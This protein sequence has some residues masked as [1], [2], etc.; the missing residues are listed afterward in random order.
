M[1]CIFD[2][3]KY[4]FYNNLQKPIFEAFLQRLAHWKCGDCAHDYFNTKPPPGWITTFASPL[5][6]T[7]SFCIR[8]CGREPF[9][10]GLSL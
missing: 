5:A 4:M 7:F 6:F 8:P 10:A 1:P 3:S 9:L 2:V